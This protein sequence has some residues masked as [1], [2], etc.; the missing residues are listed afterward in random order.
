MP[1]N[2]PHDLALQ[3]LLYSSGELEGADAREFED[4]LA[5]DQEAREALAHVVRLTLTAAGEASAP[6]PEWREEARRRL[7]PAPSIWQRV[8]GKRL[9]RGHPVV[10]SVAGAVAASLVLT[11]FSPSTPTPQAK[12]DAP[13]QLPPAAVASAW[14]ELSTSDHLLKAHDEAARRKQRAE[15]RTRVARSDEHRSP[16]TGL[17]SVKPH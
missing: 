16:R 11:L 1:E 8:V 9:Y 12:A 14:A 13:P 5:V 17:P 4:R 3:A 10:W 7:Q 6:A 2:H 15:D